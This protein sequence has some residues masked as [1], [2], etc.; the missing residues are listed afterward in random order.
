MVLVFNSSLI[1]YTVFIMKKT[2]IIIVVVIVIIIGFLTLGHRASAPVAALPANSN[3]APTVSVP[4][5]ESTAVSS[6]I[7]K[8]Q[9][10]E[11][12]FSVQYP[13]A[14]SVVDNST[15]PVFTIPVP[16]TPATGISTLQSMIYT[17]PG[18]CTFPPVSPSSIKE[19]TT[20]KTNSFTFKVIS[21]ATTTKGLN[22][23]NRMYTLEQGTT[24]HPF[25]YLFA[26]SAVSAGTKN[27][28]TIANNQ[29][30]IQA[31]DTAFT[32]MVK[33]F[34]LV[35]SANGDSEAAHPAGK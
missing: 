24:A 15:G 17:A 34:S 29:T 35:T 33:S 6:T 4:V 20:V 7:T 21:V 16:V 28:A 11:L 2:N 13:T 14:W 3:T 27:A 30:L 26:F 23:F 9:N 1:C 18:A 5:T 8:Y 10:D 12:G 22:Y 19:N 25:C 32:T 31:A